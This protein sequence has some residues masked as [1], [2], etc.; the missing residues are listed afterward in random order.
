M[1]LPLPLQKILKMN[2]LKQWSFTMLT[3]FT[4]SSKTLLSETGI[5]F[6]LLQVH[7]GKAYKNC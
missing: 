7:G 2:V 5:F 1:Q 6:F 4:T 3:V